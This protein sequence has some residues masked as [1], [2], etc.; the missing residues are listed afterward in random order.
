MVS[1]ID[2][3]VMN[4]QNQTRTKGKWGHVRYGRQR[5]PSVRVFSFSARPGD[6][7]FTCHHSNRRREKGEGEKGRATPIEG[8]REGKSASTS[9]ARR[10]SRYG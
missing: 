4:H 7:T 8:V 5:H 10:R 6:A 9:T 2:H 3:V 1:P